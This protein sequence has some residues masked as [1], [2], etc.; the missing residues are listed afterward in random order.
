MGHALENI[1]NF[2]QLTPRIDQFAS[3]AGPGFETVINI[4]MPDHDDSFD[5]E[6]SVVTGLGMT[7][8]HLPGPFDRPEVGHIEQFCRIILHAQQAQQER[9]VLVHCIMNYLT[10]IMGYDPER[11][12]SPIFDRCQIEPQWQAL[13]EL[14]IED[15]DL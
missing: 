3:I 13:M 8:I 15:F 2:V 1:R 9:T 6:G 14:K 12:R 7:Y 11:A 4:A 5:N 10:R